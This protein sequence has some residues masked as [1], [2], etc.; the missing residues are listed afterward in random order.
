MEGVQNT[1]NLGWEKQNTSSKWKYK[2]RCRKYIAQVHS[3]TN[4]KKPQLKVYL[5]GGRSNRITLNHQEYPITQDISTIT[6]LTIHDISLLTELNHHEQ[7]HNTGEKGFPKTMMISKR[8]K[9]ARKGPNLQ[10]KEVICWTNFT[11]E[12]PWS[13]KTKVPREIKRD[14]VQCWAETR[15]KCN[16]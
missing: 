8:K 6:T 16:L 11:P 2:E 12:V 10:W 13:N 7:K 3:T 4:K 9:T 5:L 15:T 1:F 14:V